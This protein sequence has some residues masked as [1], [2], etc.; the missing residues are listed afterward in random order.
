M[1]RQRKRSSRKKELVGWL[2]M[3]KAYGSGKV[4]ITVHKK[5]TSVY[6]HR[7]LSGGD[8]LVRPTARGWIPEAATVWNDLTVVG[9]R[10]R[11]VVRGPPET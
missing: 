7:H 10:F 6:L 2:Q 4:Q 5:G 11:S 3:Q 8:H 1:A 9:S